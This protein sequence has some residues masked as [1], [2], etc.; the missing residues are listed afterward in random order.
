MMEG[1]CYFER[2]ATAPSRGRAARSITTTPNSRAVTRILPPCATSAGAKP[3]WP[4]RV[5]PRK[6]A[7]NV[8]L[9]ITDDTGFG[10]PSTF[11]G[12]VPTPNLDRVA[13][14]Y[15]NFYSTV[16]CSPTRAAPRLHRRRQ[17]ASHFG[18]VRQGMAIMWPKVITDKGG[19]RN[20]FHPVIDIVP[21]ILEAAQVKQPNGVNGA[22]T[23][24]ATL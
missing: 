19:I 24:S 11:G 12:V 15:A 23:S 14:R 4:P 3:Y 5:E 1:H 13:L 21:T 8:P 2:R 9:I 7:P 10:T 20:Q 18:G 22:G 16:L 17:V 6:G